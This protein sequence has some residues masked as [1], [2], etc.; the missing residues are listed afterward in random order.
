[1]TQNRSSTVMQ[2]RN[3]LIGSSPR[4]TISK[5]FSFRPQSSTDN[6]HLNAAA[7]FAAHPPDHGAGGADG[8]RS[9][10]AVRFAWSSNAGSRSPREGS[11]VALYRHRTHRG[12]LACRGGALR[13]GITRTAGRHPG[14]RRLLRVEEGRR[15]STGRAPGRM[16]LLGQ[17]RGIAVS[18]S[19]GLVTTCAGMGAC[20]CSSRL[21]A[22]A[23]AP[24]GFGHPRGE[25]RNTCT[26]LHRSERSGLR[27]LRGSIPVVSGA[28]GRAVPSH[29]EL[30]IAHLASAGTAAKGTSDPFTPPGKDPK[31]STAC[32][33]LVKASSRASGAMSACSAVAPRRR[34]CSSP[35]AS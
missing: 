14:R 19:S 30:L 34:S 21:P 32:R 11:Y 15:Q 6:V 5:P 8:V 28:P 25:L 22:S 31:P 18:V 17:S 1:M 7:P 13:S 23:A 9:G 29:T 2:Q 4:L 12:G 20:L 24:S 35:S 3:K 33:D 26:T 10:F 16:A 27:A